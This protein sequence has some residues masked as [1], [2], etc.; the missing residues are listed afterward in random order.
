MKKLL[1]S[2]LLIPLIAHAAVTF[3]VNGGTGTA[4]KPTIGQVLVGLVSGIYSPTAT[5]SLGLAGLNSPSFTGTALFNNII[6][7]LNSSTTNMSLGGLF[8]DSINA[9]G[10]SGQLLSSTG[11]STLWKTVSSSGVFATTSIN[12]LAT[13]TFVFA[14]T[15]TGTDISFSTSTAGVFLNVPTASALNRGALSSTDWST[16]NNKAPTANPTF[17]GVVRTGLA[18]STAITVGTLHATNTAL[19]SGIATFASNARITYGSSTAFTIGTLHS[20][21]SAL[22]SGVAT[23]ASNTRMTYASSTAITVGTLLATSTISMNGTQFMDSSRNLTNIGTVSAGTTTITGN[24]TITG[25]YIP[26]VVGYAS[27]GTITLNVNTTDE[28]TTTVNQTTTFANPT[29]T[30]I[31]GAMYMF[32]LLSTTT[33]TVSWGTLYASSTDLSFPTSIA[34]GTTEVLWKYDSWKN[35]YLLLGLLKTFQ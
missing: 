34:S 18:S 25:N 19:F 22:F 12:G 5:S 28:A 33:Q 29:G 14:T 9:T 4:T 24:L 32:T 31:N 6:V 3:P 2:L 8:Y 20:T 23:F 26:R 1:L 21:S 11:T 13:T 35:K 10:T 15:T 17:T 27:A 7:N 30:P 16:F